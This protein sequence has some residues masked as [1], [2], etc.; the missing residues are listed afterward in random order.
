MTFKQKH[1]QRRES[2]NNNHILAKSVSWIIA[3]SK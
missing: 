1:I 2:Y 3:Q